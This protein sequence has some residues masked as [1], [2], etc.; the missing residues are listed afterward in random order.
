MDLFTFEEKDFQVIEDIEFDETIQRPEEIR[1]FTL[2]EQI[3][4]A[5]GK[6]IPAG[7]TTKFQLKI[8]QGEVERLR[9][10]Y[11]DFITPT[12]DTYEVR[13]P[14]YGQKFDWISPVYQTNELV[15]YDYESK[16]SPLFSEDRIKLPR[17]YRAMTTALPHPFQSAAE[18]VPF[19]TKT[20]T[21]F[22]N[23]EGKEPIRGL[24]LYPYTRT[25]YH[26][27]GSFDVAKVEMAGTADAVNFIGYYARKRPVEVPNPLLEHPFLQSS[28][29]IFVET[30]APLGDVVPSLDAV[31]TH[32]VPVTSDPYGEGM[33]YLKIYDVKLTDIPWSMWKSKFPP[34]EQAPVEAEPVALDFP[35]ST[36]DKPA[37]KLLEFYSPYAPALSTR[38][39]LMNQMDGGELVVHMLMSMVGDNGTVAQLPGADSERTYPP[40]TIDECQLAAL[41]FQ[42]FTTRGVLHREFVKGKAVYTCMPVELIL[43]ERK[44]AGFR[45]RI[46]WT[47]GIG[48]K[49]LQ[50][51]V[52][53]LRSRMPV[54]GL[55]EK[56]ENRP[57]TA[58]GEISGLRK[59]VLAVLA[60]NRRFAE[61]KMTDVQE[62]IKDAIL[63]K[64]TY[65]DATGLFV[66]CR[67]TLALLNGDLIT[68]RLAFYDLWTAKVDGFRV[69]KHCGEHVA[70]DMLQEQLEF[71]DEGRL[72]RRA[73]TLDAKTFSGHSIDEHVSSLSGIKTLFKLDQASDE[74]FFM[75]ISLIHVLPDAMQLTPI[76]E[77]GRKF[78]AA[79][80]AKQKDAEGTV[81]VAQ[82]VLLMQSHVPALIPRRSFGSKPLTI[83]GY[84]RDDPKPDGY[85]IVDSLVMVLYKTMDAFPTSF[86][87][88]SA[89]FK[90][91]ILNNP[92][93]VRSGV[94]Q[95]IELMLAKTP[96][97]RAALTRGKPVAPTESST[98][99]KAMIPG[100]ISMPPS[101]KFGT[102]TSLPTCPSYRPY[103]ISEG[104][105]RIR[106][107]RVPLRSPINQFEKPDAMKKLITV[108]ETN[109]VVPIPIEV[110]DKDVIA[111]LK[112]KSSFAT[113]DWRTN[114]MIANRLST[115][116]AISSPTK[117]L[118][119]TQKSDDLRDITKGFVNA[120]VGEIKKNPVSASRLE[121]M[122]QK[123]ATLVLLL[124]DKA[125]AKA[126]TNTLR[127]KER[128]TFTDRLRNMSDSEREIMKEL[129]DRG[130]APTIVGKGDR[131][132]FAKQLEEQERQVDED[133]GVGRPVDYV[134]QGDVPIAEDMVERGN[135]GDYSNAANN[136][137]RDY[138]QPDQF[139][140]D[141]RGI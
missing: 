63:D 44:Q 95:V 139:D 115:A 105:P 91:K 134:E 74:V 118:D 127:A 104:E 82:M 123:D 129:I 36:A 92:K 136:D 97:L 114:I 98:T 50:N 52:K 49:I 22:V 72:I 120:I 42:D 83:N 78:A 87:G 88:A 112:M 51:Y 132:L 116:F 1:F 103:Y 25:A 117:T 101:E 137:G 99:P 73:E 119:T 69:C 21:E 18:G 106:Q 64:Q 39:W 26:E 27:D 15:P 124:T 86:S 62:L 110:K 30:T 9:G 19:A 11:T 133:T 28:E 35:S 13:E 140:D 55:Q 96:G 141:E 85:T 53:A 45:N 67:H 109:R 17:F 81:G 58:S 40:T 54:R 48:S 135:Y 107:P 90:R 79:L 77:T 8:L 84:P 57:K 111:R 70:T 2:D 128:I 130:L 80:G 41:S 24:P 131:V 94:V 47:E 126:V 20:P 138:E 66:I 61:D 71:T 37:D 125:K 113:E 89:G 121:E 12:A 3:G 56:E 14:V 59:A 60:D 16:W 100:N 31:L 46:Q 4:D 10:L 65:V 6:M 68:N 34:A 122:I 43:Q 7:R 38:Y 75:L 102:I 5:Y 93:L 76:L 108:S 23:Q 33:A 32:A 29:P